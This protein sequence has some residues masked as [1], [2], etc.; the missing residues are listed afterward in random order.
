MQV[1]GAY[2][3]CGLWLD[4]VHFKWPE[5]AAFDP[6]VI[7]TPL[8]MTMVLTMVPSNTVVERS[9]TYKS[10]E[11]VAFLSIQRTWTGNAYSTYT[12]I[13]CLNNRGL[14]GILRPL[15]HNHVSRLAPVDVVDVGI[16]GKHVA[17]ALQKTKLPLYQ[18]SSEVH[19]FFFRGCLVLA[20]LRPT[21]GA[22]GCCQAS[23]VSTSSEL[24]VGTAEM[25]RFVG[26]GVGGTAMRWYYIRLTH[27]TGRYHH[28]PHQPSSS[29]FLTIINRDCLAIF[30]HVISYWPSV[31]PCMNHH[32]P[33]FT[34]W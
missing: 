19:H 17:A 13:A 25:W 24:Q 28:E 7:C 18:G 15:A 20:K 4:P 14:K 22:M 9:T 27:A 30:F 12:F 23:T 29:R 8:A 16:P 11:L 2:H 10:I 5:T 21:S 34:G 3:G 6:L 26:S 31:W 33:S 32:Q 1:F